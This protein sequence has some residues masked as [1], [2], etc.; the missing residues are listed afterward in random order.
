MSD[1]SR[2][3]IALESILV[4]HGAILCKEL[5]YVRPLFQLHFDLLRAS[6]QQRLIVPGDPLCQLL[7]T[8]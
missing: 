6:L 2:A 4:C 8:Y 5:A 1:S 7:S 3:I